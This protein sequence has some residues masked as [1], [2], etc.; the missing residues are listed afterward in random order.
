MDFKLRYADANSG[1]DLWLPLDAYGVTS[2]N[3]S[4]GDDLDRSPKS[5]DDF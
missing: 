4:L 3:L 1:R 5:S 2:I